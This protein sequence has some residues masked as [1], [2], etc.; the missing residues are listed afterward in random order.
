[1]SSHDS[2]DPQCAHVLEQVYAFLDHELDNASNDAIR[3]HLQ[4][5]EPCLDRFDVEQALK[6]LVARRCG[7]ELAPAQ[8]RARILVQ[9]RGTRD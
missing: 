3:M 4:A 8:L 7:G 9:L 2:V 6:S 1:M 5:C